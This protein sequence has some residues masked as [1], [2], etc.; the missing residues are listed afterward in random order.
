MRERNMK[1]KN[2]NNLPMMR[3][4]LAVLSALLLVGCSLQTNDPYDLRET[5]PEAVT[6]DAYLSRGVETR[7]GAPGALT[8]TSLQSEATGFG[9]FGYHT[10]ASLYSQAALPN[11]MYNTHV[12]SNRWTYSPIKYWPNEFG[13]DAQSVNIDRL[14]FFAYAPWVQVNASTGV[15]TSYYNNSSA[16]KSTKTGITRLTRAT[17]A[18][19]PKVSYK[20]SFVPAECVDLCWG[21]AKD[22]LTAANSSGS[23][24]GTN[25]IA[26]GFP[27]VDVYRPKI[28]NKIGFKFYH[29]LAALNVQ[30]VANIGGDQRFDPKQT[31]IYVRSVSFEGFTDEGSLNLNSSTGPAGTGPQWL[32]YFATGSVS[33]S[34]VTVHDGLR[35]GREPVAVDG[36]ETPTGLNK[37]I[38]QSLAYSPDPEV[39]SAMPGVTDSVSNLFDSTDR[40]SPIYVIPNNDPLKVTITY[41]VETRDRKI[42]GVYLADGVTNGSR[43]ENTI[44]KEIE[45]DH[46]PLILSAGQVYFINLRLGLNSVDFTAT[47]NSWD[48]TE[49]A[50]DVGLPTNV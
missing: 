19:D 34:P 24:E 5:A 35:D 26:Q 2:L 1:R 40:S 46:R 20:V 32:N 13:I 9:V 44:T 23:Q 42:L 14:T 8:T 41:D 4:G 29:A 15:L 39:D 36:T 38:I 10:D 11:F 37:N 31:K 27:F 25:H 30:V 7:A 49:S 48:S 16:E 43:I 28:A 45:I 6:F 50:V 21:V 12:S 22:A 33:T 3:P 17:D 18:G 47:V